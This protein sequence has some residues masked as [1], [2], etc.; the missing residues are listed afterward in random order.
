MRISDVIQQEENS[1]TGKDNKCP[2]GVP[3]TKRHVWIILG[4][5]LESEQTEVSGSKKVRGLTETPSI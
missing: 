4:T 3:V 5:K 2:Q 1:D